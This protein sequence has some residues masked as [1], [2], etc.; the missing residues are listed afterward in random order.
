M[1]SCSRWAGRV[2]VLVAGAAVLVTGCGTDA[3]PVATAATGSIALSAAP[4]ATQDDGIVQHT[5]TLA[6]GAELPGGVRE[7]WGWSVVAVADVVTLAEALGVPGSPVALGANEGNGW[8]VGDES[9]R[10]PTLL[11]GGQG[12]WSASEPVGV[13][14]ELLACFD[15]AQGQGPEAAEAC[16]RTEIA[17]QESL[18]A[19]L[20]TYDAVLA[21]AQRIFGDQVAYRPGPA[22]TTSVTVDIEY[23]AG[24]APTGAVGSYG[25]GLSNDPSDP[26]YWSAEGQLGTPESLGTFTTLAAADVVARLGDFRYGYEVATTYRGT[27]QAITLTRA[28]AAMVTFVGAG[29]VTLQLPGYQLGDAAGSVWY[30]VAV[31]DEYFSS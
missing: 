16:S 12:R 7:G 21:D 1:H 22:S 26:L 3:L 8:R 25:V 19:N 17:R 13:S 28:E 2:A 9:Q 4:D 6:D 29:G 27:P 15:A 23:L 11:V 30:V 18:A 14:A 5:Y 10:Q 24:D 31:A 20:P